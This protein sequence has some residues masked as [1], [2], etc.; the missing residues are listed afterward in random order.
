MTAEQEQALDRLL[1]V[2]ERNGA[3]RESQAHSLTLNWPSMAAAL[4]DLLAAHERPV[5]APFRRASAAMREER[6]E[7]GW[8][9]CRALP[10]KH[11]KHG[12]YEK[13][14]EARSDD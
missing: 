5:P 9:F 7:P 3:Y 14:M 8:C 12:L 10:F 11:S 13:P 4:G 2:S 1:A 6:V